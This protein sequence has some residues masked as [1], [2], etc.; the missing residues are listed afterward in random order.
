[1]RFGLKMPGV[2]TSTI[3]ALPSMAMARMR[4]RVVCTL[5][6]TIDTFEPV[7][8]FTSVDFPALGAPMMAQKPHRV[9]MSS[10]FIVASVMV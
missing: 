7:S 9:G 10:G 5:W 1:M 2:S 3:C 8:W 6:L 4:A